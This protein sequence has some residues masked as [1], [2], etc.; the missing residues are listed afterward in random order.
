MPS[1]AETVPPT[2]ELATLDWTATARFLD[3]AVA[4]GAAPG[5]ALGVSYR[6]ARMTYGTGRL[7]ID[8]ATRPDRNTVYDL[9]SLTKVVGLTTAVMLAVDEGL[10]ELDAPVQRYAPQFQG[11]G[12]DSV[13]VRH[14]LTHSSGLP[15]WR[16]LY[17]E[18][19]TRDSALALV[20]GTALDTTP[21]AVMRYSDL[22]AILLTE[23]VQHVW[24]MR[25]DSVLARRVFGPLGMTSTTFR[26]PAAWRIRIAPTEDDP[27]RGYVVR[28][29][30]HDE[31]AFRLEGISGHAG[32]FSTAPDLLTF[33]EWLLE[34]FVPE[35]PAPVCLEGVRCGA[36]PVG[37]VPPPTVVPAFAT[38]QDV[39]AESSRALG[40]DTPSGLST[41]GS[42]MSARS[43]GH[44]GFTGT[45]LWIDPAR[46]LVVVLLTN[47]VHPSREDSRIGPVRRGVADRVVL[48]LDPHA[49]PRPDAVVEAR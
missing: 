10:M 11:P 21:G 37:S 23:A 36:G 43:F 35:T 44:T 46:R 22:G 1:P 5:A 45:S 24:D 25:L 38:R 13:T 32:L 18:A 28:G 29:E 2:G 27:W 12:K 40:W 34:A 4:G 47:R 7:G 30:V 31:N 33:G 42:L 16:P 8:D 3:S 19:P 14:L 9:A 39:V 48:T 26:P 15:P 49:K 20:Y 6:G 41:A 17:L